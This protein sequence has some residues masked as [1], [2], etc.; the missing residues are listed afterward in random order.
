MLNCL[1]ANPQ[2]MPSKKSVELDTC[3]NIGHLASAVPNYRNWTEIYETT[4][5]LSL[6]VCRFMGT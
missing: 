5:G 2:K 6:T 1:V 3:S 4:L